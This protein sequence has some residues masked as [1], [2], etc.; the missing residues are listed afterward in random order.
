ME[1]QLPRVDSS[2]HTDKENNQ[3]LMDDN[4]ETRIK[5]PIEMD[6]ET[7]SST[8]TKTTDEDTAATSSSCS[9]SENTIDKDP[10]SHSNECEKALEILKE[11]AKLGET[12]PK[13]RDYSY[14]VD[15]DDAFGTSSSVE[16]STC[17]L[18]DLVVNKLKI[19]TENEAASLAEDTTAVSTI[20]DR[21][22]EETAVNTILDRQCEEPNSQVSL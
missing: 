9:V 14:G 20:L 17:S 7:T 3:T 10:E 13:K 5:T 22:C 12:T 4:T 19:S 21:Q 6:E 1:G 15:V 18:D 11:F 8:G 2:F 16:K